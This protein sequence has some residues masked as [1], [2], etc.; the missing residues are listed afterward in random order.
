M[1]SPFAEL[2]S[3]KKVNTKLKALLIGRARALS[4]LPCCVGIQE[5]NKLT[6]EE[7][8]EQ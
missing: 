5:F 1:T 4:I 8:N 3:L 7:V 2:L 6:K